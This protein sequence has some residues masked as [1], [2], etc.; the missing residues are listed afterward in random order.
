MP[1]NSKQLKQ[2]QSLLEG[3]TIAAIE[4]P[5]AAEA[6]AKFVLTDGT[7]FRLHA[8]ELG[9]WIE[10][11]AGVE[12]YNSLDDIMT[13]YGHYTYDLIPKYKFDLPDAIVNMNGFILEVIAP[14]GKV[15][16]ADTTKF[17]A[18]DQSIVNHPEGRKILA[19]YAA[20]GDMYATGFT[21]YINPTCPKEL[22][23]K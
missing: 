15:F 12:G 21:T 5:N 16:T 17:N 22:I 9:F 10:T 13:D 4:K 2:L 18:Y 3:K 6:I 1:D 20:M 14:D 23:R 8:T 7:A 11:T 19:M